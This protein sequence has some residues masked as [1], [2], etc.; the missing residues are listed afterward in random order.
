MFRYQWGLFIL[1]TLVLIGVIWGHNSHHSHLKCKQS[2]HAIMH[3]TI[4]YLGTFHDTVSQSTH[5]FIR[6]HNI[7]TEKVDHITRLCSK[8]VYMKL[9]GIMHMS[10][11][12]GSKVLLNYKQTM[13]AKLQTNTFQ[14]F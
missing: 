13:F 7:S 8:Y 12:T 4:V 11:N 1:P 5:L 9:T 10:E 6:L 2:T 3:K 14:K